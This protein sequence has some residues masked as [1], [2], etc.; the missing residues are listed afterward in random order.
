MTTKLNDETNQTIERM[1]ARFF[2]IQ[3]DGSIRRRGEWCFRQQANAVKSAAAMPG[4]MVYDKEAAQYVTGEPVMATAVMPVVA[5]DAPVIPERTETRLAEAE[6]ELADVSKPDTRILDSM[7]E[8]LADGKARGQRKSRSKKDGKPKALS[9]K[10]EAQ[11][12]A[13]VKVSEGKASKAP[14]AK[15][16]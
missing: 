7:I 12:R 3:P 1:K 14:K 10:G 6:A 16:S 8:T 2:L 13:G 5:S 9:A 4:V 11:A 15:K